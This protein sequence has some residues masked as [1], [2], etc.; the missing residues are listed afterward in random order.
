MISVFTEELAGFCYMKGCTA[1]KENAGQVIKCV[2]EH[3]GLI[4]YNLVA[5]CTDGAPSMRGLLVR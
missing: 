3:L 5:V 2:S 4:L 1:G